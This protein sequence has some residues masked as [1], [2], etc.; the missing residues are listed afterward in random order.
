[1]APQTFA[2]NE[3]YESDYV[4]VTDEENDEEFA[5]NREISDS[6][7][8]DGD[9]SQ[10]DEETPTEERQFD[11]TLLQAIHA[12]R[13]SR[14]ARSTSLQVSEGGQSMGVLGR[15]SDILRGGVQRS[16]AT[17]RIN[18]GFGSV[19]QGRRFTPRG[20]SLFTNPRSSH[21]LHNMRAG[22][23]HQAPSTQ[24]VEDIT[25]LADPV[26]TNTQQSNE[27]RPRQ[28]ALRRGA[29]GFKKNQ[30]WT[31]EQMERALT[32]YDEGMSMREAS[33]CHGIP[34]STFREWCYGERKSRKRGPACVLSPTEEKLIVE[35]LV[36]MCE[37][38]LGLSPTALKM[39]VFEITKDRVTPFKNGIPGDGWLRWFKH[40][41][42]ELTLRVSQ[43]L[44]ASRAQG[45]CKENVQS[46]YENLNH[47]YS[48]HKY[49]PDRVWN[50]DESGVQA[51]RNGGGIVI[52]RRGSRRVHS[53]VPNQREWL[54]V[55]VCINAAGL[56][57]PSFYVFKGMRFRQNYIERC[58]PG[59]TMSMQP[60]AWMTSYLFSAWISHFIESVQR[61]GGISTD[62]RHLLILDGHASHITFD[63]VQEA[64]EAGLDLLT[65]PSHTSHA[66]QPL[67]VSVFKPFKTF[68]KEYRDFW[69]SRNL[70]Q[71]ATKQTLAHWVSLALKRALTPHNIRSGFSS[72]G[73]LPFNRDA[74]NVHLGPSATFDEQG[75]HQED[76]E[77]GLDHQHDNRR[78]D[79]QDD[80]YELDQPDCGSEEQLPESGRVSIAD[81]LDQVPASTVLHFYVDADTS[82]PAIAEEAAGLDPTVSN[83]ESITQFLTL[84]TITR[85]VPRR[86]LNDPIMDFTKSIILTSESY[87]NAVEKLQQ[88]KEEA[89]RAKERNRIEREETK[90]RKVLEREEEQRQ[91]EARAAELAEARAK[92]ALERTARAKKALEREEA[93]RAKA[94]WREEVARLKAEREA[95]RARARALRAAKR[96]GRRASR[97]PEVSMVAESAEARQTDSHPVRGGGGEDVRSPNVDMQEPQGDFSFFHQHPAMYATSSNGQVVSNHPLHQFVAPAQYTLSSQPS[98][99]LSHLRAMP[100]LSLPYP[101]ATMHPQPWPFPPRREH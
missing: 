84:P 81:E 62:Q 3:Q 15:Q 47:L 80:G 58:E 55:L 33:Q 63:V 18:Q 45:L 28:Q 54:S 46:F 31:K 29:K 76:D 57:I 70:N 13:D 77:E 43:A 4:H 38:G 48:L 95:L 17:H 42:P 34:Y 101:A 94:L 37:R 19:Q 27:Q 91:R 64:R 44:E 5:P 79:Q 60:R 51:G 86:R 21:D 26:N 22:A 50:C 16:M 100:Q 53:I 41:H 99:M 32:A 56:A 39:K 71:P 49:P 25:D 61:M 8:W 83:P 52:A 74:M 35:Y 66:M 24:S 2:R 72:T 68:F 69:T 78:P 67:D 85:R 20:V 73:I 9:S 6:R 40:R 90:R 30:L 75:L 97:H 1:M 12:E 93:A 92:K 87:M 59:A 11:Y 98:D 65:L 7:V 82:D 36:N 89:T 23:Q 10:S 88:K 14:R 96:P